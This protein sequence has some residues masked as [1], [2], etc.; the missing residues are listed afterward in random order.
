MPIRRS[1]STSSTSGAAASRRAVTAV[2]VATN[3]GMLSYRLVTVPSARLCAEAVAARSDLSTT[4]YR[5]GAEAC[6]GAAAATVDNRPRAAIAARRRARDGMDGIGGAL[7]L[8]FGTRVLPP[9]RARGATPVGAGCGYGAQN[10][11]A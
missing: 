3:A 8:G 5:A 7:R 2:S 4:M 10:A 9:C 11:V 1:G 6:A